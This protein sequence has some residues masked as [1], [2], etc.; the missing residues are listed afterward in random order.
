M[1]AT[2]SPGCAPRARR[3][4]RGG[5]PMDGLAFDCPQCNLRHDGL[6][7]LAYGEPAMQLD[8][9]G[10]ER[11]FRK[12]NDDFRILEDRHFFVRA[13]FEI[14]II[15]QSQSLEWGVWGSLSKANFQLYWDSFDDTD[16]SRIGAMFSY[17]SNELNGYPG[18]LGLRSGLFPRDDRQRPLLILDDEQDHPLVR[19]Q[20]RGI[21]ASRAI[22]LAMPFLHPQGRA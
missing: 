19:D 12:I 16:Q 20:Q 22:E 9:A 7:A 6:P 21:T 10:K 3:I 13:V 1:R 14:P 11:P 5:E 8:D 4:W 18:S 15:G 17:M 2:I